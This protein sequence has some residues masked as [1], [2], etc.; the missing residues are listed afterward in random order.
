MHFKLKIKFHENKPTNSIS[1]IGKEVNFSNLPENV[2][3]KFLDLFANSAKFRKYLEDGI[4]N[5]GAACKDLAS[6]YLQLKIKKIK[7][8]IEK[9]G[10]G[11]FGKTS[12]EL[13]IE[14]NVNS[15][16][17]KIKDAQWCKKKLTESEV[18]K[19]LEE[20]KLQ[21][22]ISWSINE[23]QKGDPFK[24]I[25][26]KNIKYSFYLKKSNVKKDLEYYFEHSNINKPKQP[27]TNPPN[28]K[29]DIQLLHVSR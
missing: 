26:E 16:S 14:A 3:K 7:P 2:Q 19:L 15:V 13:E 24:T 1:N 27:S 21:K 8:I 29:N 28:F 20:D 10:I 18:N 11:I 6:H 12:V 5:M 4:S 9:S 22:H 23:L 25:T 17:K